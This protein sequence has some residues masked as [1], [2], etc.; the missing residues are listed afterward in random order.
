MLL[1]KEMIKQWACNLYCFTGELPRKKED[2][3][4]KSPRNMGDKEGTTKGLKV[5]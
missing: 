4:D 1:G 2:R 5:K 3:Q